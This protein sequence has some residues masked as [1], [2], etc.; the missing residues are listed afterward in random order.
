[1]TQHLEQELKYQIAGPAEFEKVLQFLGP[2]GEVLEQC[3]HYFSDRPER[4]SPD[5]SLRVRQEN[6]LYELTFKLGKQQSQGYFQSTEVECPIDSQQV[7]ELLNQPIWSESLWELPPLERLRREF[8]VERLVLLGSLRNQ[9]HC[10][11]QPA[12]WTAELDI[13]WFPGGRTDYELEIETAEVAA[14]EQA[15]QPIEQYLIRQ[16]KTKFRRF[17]E[18]LHLDH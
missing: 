2:A 10:C 17:L 15:L 14:V 8:G 13:T 9:R 3:N 12:G 6:E 1:M 16:T 7:E 4:P 5:W 18:A 11:P